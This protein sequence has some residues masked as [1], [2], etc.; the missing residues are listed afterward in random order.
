LE[1]EKFIKDN[2]DK[3]VQIHWN[4]ILNDYA[5]NIVLA[6]IVLN[7]L[8]KEEFFKEESN[9]FESIN[10]RI[11]DY[12]ENIKNPNY[13]I[14]IVGAIKAGKSTLINA[15]IGHELASTNVTPETATLTKFKYSEKNCLKIKFYTKNDWDKIWYDA[16]EKKAT[17]FIEGYKQLNADEVKNLL[18]NKKDVYQEFD[19]IEEMKK[20][21]SRWTSSR[22]KEHYFVK[23]L[24]IGIN[25]LKLPTQI[26]LVDTPGLNDVIDYRSKITR[27]YISNA[28]AV[29]VCV[30][31][32]TLRNEEFLTIT[33]VFSKARYKKDKVYILGTQ[34]DIMNSAED[35]Q[36]QRAL[37]LDILK[38]EE[39][40]GNTSTAINHLLGISSFAY[41]EALKLNKIFTRET[42]LKLTNQKLINFDDA[43]KIIDLISENKYTEEMLAEL[44]KRIINFSQIEKV[45]KIIQNEL[46][47]DFNNS[48]IT[49]FVEQYKILVEE[50]NNFRNN[51]KNILTEK[52]DD[53]ERTSEELN[54]KVEEERRKIEE[55]EKIN[56]S[57]EEKI[58]ETTDSFNLDFGKLENNFKELEKGIKK[59]KIDK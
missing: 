39:C 6:Q 32:K 46:L 23:E 53:L 5:K 14:A 43:G 25:D 36:E 10:R 20:E 40:Y 22:S 3:L 9:F 50:I 33:K 4:D 41:S 57:L 13:Q 28:N 8:S 21:I 34:I 35:W 16:T 11:N 1:L 12:I 24:E 15:L 54:K 59:I 55:L 37:W 26:C 49:D 2:S 56:A 45:N 38:K 47:Q 42:V 51:Y 30:N 7:N 44:K 52:K 18:L 29:I 48:M 19:S 17:T 31:A 27:D 58:K